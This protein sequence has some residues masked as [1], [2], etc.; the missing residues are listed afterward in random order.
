MNLDTI[1]DKIFV[2]NLDFRKD[3]FQSLLNH[4]KEIGVGNVERIP[5]TCMDFLSTIPRTK[6]A[7]ISCF[8]SHLKTFR[9]ANN[10]GLIR[11]LILEDD[12]LFLPESSSQVVKIEKFMRICEWEVFYLGANLRIYNKENFDRMAR[13]TPVQDGIVKV[14]AAG[15]THAIAYTNSFIEKV[16]EEYPSD[17]DFFQK[18]FTC[19]SEFSVF[20]VFL[21][22]FT[23][24]NNISKYCSFPVVCV[25]FDSF[26][27]IQ[28]CNTKYGHEILSSWNNY[29]ITLQ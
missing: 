27:D 4:L 8:H 22:T 26:S 20:D 6:L 28:F 11:I 24:N 21:N 15:T 2:I 23:V 3:R 12:C 1:F 9:M 17:E 19:K 25:Q 16:C 5:A 13:V 18:A 29:S 10:Q 14:D 7:Q